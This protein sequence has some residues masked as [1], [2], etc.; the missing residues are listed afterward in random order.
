MNVKEL[1][2]AVET[3]KS[4]REVA[5]KLGEHTHQH[6]KR[7]AI[8]YGINF[9]HFNHGTTYRKLVGT[10]I[11]KLTI[12][13]VGIKRSVGSRIREFCKCLCECGK[14]CEKRLDGVKSRRVISCGCAIT[15]RRHYQS[16][17][18]NKAFTGVGEICAT[19]FTDIKRNA[20]R[21]SIVFDVTIEYIWKLFEKQNRKCALSGLDLFFGPANYPM[22][23]NASLDRIDSS[24]GYVEDNVQWV[25]KDV[26]LMKRSFS[27]KYFI[28]LCKLI[29]GAYNAK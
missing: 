25:H 27:Q 11:G 7:K 5:R 26:N 6:C 29:A 17:N 16:G 14:I 18:K 24:R 19:K 4:F 9:D 10:K 13:E 2:Q 21:R 8:L 28:E 12:Q 3:S 20:S 15:D 23:T 22:E 1:R